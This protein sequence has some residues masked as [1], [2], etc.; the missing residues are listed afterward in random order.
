M[1]WSRPKPKVQRG[2]APLS[3]DRFDKFIAAMNWY[4]GRHKNR[5]E[6]SAAPGYFDAV[7]QWFARLSLD[8]QERVHTVVYVYSAPRYGG[9]EAAVTHAALL[10]SV[11]PPPDLVRKDWGHA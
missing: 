7:S 2:P 11:P 8:D 6:Y 5:P 9:E 10:P 1:P 3:D 4:V